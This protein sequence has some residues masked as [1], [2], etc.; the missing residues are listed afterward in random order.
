MSAGP[1]WSRSLRL[2]LLAAEIP[3]GIAEGRQPV[4]KTMAL[5]LKGFPVVC[6]EQRAV[7]GGSSSAA[8][9]C[10]GPGK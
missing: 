1:E 10:S 8:E 7:L 9:A 6:A 3:E 5:R 4:G 2:T